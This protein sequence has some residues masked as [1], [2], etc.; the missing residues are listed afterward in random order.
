MHYA[1]TAYCSGRVLWVCAW[2]SISSAA[3]PEL[4]TLTLRRHSVDFSGASFYV[5]CWGLWL[6]RAVLG[7]FGSVAM[8]G[9]THKGSPNPYFFGG[10]A[11]AAFWVAIVGR[12]QNTLTRYCHLAFMVRLAK[13]DCSFSMCTS[14]GS[15][16]IEQVP[17]SIL[18]PSK[19]HASRNSLSDMI[20]MES[21]CELS[22]ERSSGIANTLFLMCNRVP[23][24]LVI[25]A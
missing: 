24:K 12:K 6:M 8:T 5:S 11:I 10:M 20:H 22:R 9:I 4:S 18:E 19:Y 17:T 23:C 16:R 1:M 15:T 21:F 3:S 25:T 14:Q 2:P 13:G 7:S